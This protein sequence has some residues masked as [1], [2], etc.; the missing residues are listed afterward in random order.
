MPGLFIDCQPLGIVGA[1]K[2]SSRSCTWQRVRWFGRK[3]EPSEENDGR[4]QWTLLD[5][6]RSKAKQI[7]EPGNLRKRTMLHTHLHIRAEVV[8]AFEN[9]VS[10]HLA[11]LSATPLAKALMIVRQRADPCTSSPLRDMEPGRPRYVVFSPDLLE[12]SPR[13]DLES[14]K[15]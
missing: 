14:M 9:A 3:P 8:P 11:T 5:Q 13:S 2:N 10:R 4:D 7:V 12:E 15:R 1:G 6:G